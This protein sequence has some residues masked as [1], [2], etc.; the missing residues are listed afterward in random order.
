MSK[1]NLDIEVQHFSYPYGKWNYKIKE[2]VEKSSLASAVATDPV[3]TI[4][5]NTDIFALPRMEV[6]RNMTL[7]KYMVSGA[8]PGLSQLIIRR[9]KQPE[10]LLSR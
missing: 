8:Y 6:T 7:F 1:D 3:S 2:I 5:A 9:P 4:N 10:K